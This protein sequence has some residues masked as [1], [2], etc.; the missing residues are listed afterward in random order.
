[1][2]KKRYIIPDYDLQFEALPKINLSTEFEPGL[3]EPSIP[4]GGKLVQLPGFN[5]ED[6]EGYIP[7]QRINPLSGI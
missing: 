1:M 2:T 6:F 5:K 7:E 3:S 4:S